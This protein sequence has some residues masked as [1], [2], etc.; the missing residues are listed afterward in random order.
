MGSLNLFSL[1]S[2]AT[3]CARRD[4]KPAPGGMLEVAKLTPGRT[5]PIVPPS[6]VGA[7]KPMIFELFHWSMIERPQI[8]A[9]ERKSLGDSLRITREAWLREVFGKMIAFGHHGHQ[10]HYV[11]ET[12]TA[13][14]AGPLMIGRIGRQVSVKENEP[15]DAGLHE[16]QRDAWLASAFIMDPTYHDHGQ[17]VTVQ[18][19]EDIGK[20]LALLTSLAAHINRESPP[21]PYSLSVAPIIDASTFWHFVNANKN[22]VTNVSFDLV[23]PNMFDG[24][25][26]MDKELKELRDLEK[27]RKIKLDLENPDSLNLET[28]R[29]HDIVDYA[30]QGGGDIKARAKGKKSYN[31]KRKIKTV[32]VEEIEG[33]ATEAA[34]TELISNAK[35]IIFEL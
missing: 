34:V 22:A 21:E 29:I 23:P 35:R 20:P 33:R 4:S 30:A 11:P 13:R 27:A 5:P 28:K 25:E 31:S 1:R 26:N 17:R 16:T 6:V 2:H 18:Y 19:R 15:P 9:F 14:D 8:D 3:S 12:M 7:R 32:H 24:P 10:F